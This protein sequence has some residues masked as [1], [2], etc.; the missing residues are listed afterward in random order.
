MP[1]AFNA[2]EA[3]ELAGD[4]Y[5]LAIDISIIDRL[6]DE[7]DCSFDQL[8]TKIGSGKVRMGKMT[9]LVRGLL[10]REHPDLSLDETG[11]LLFGHG[12]EISGAM[13]RLFA[14]AWPEQAAETKGKNPR[15]ARRGTGASS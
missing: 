8:M 12:E 3:I 6:E 4:E 7:F 10:A 5:T 1:K 15:K 13:E 2:S 14:K 11:S 9:R